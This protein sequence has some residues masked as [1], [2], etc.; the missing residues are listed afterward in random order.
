MNKLVG[1]LVK[2][3][4]DDSSDEGAAVVR[5]EGSADDDIEGG[6]EVDEGGAEGEVVD[7][8]KGDLSCVT[9]GVNVIGA[10]GEDVGVNGDAGGVSVGEIDDD[11]GKSI[12]VKVGDN[13]EGEVACGFEL[14]ID[15]GD[16]IGN[17]EVVG[18]AA[19]TSAGLFDG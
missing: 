5:G 10:D 16:E 17:R 9:D 15:C 6:D 8:G 11:E 12:S 13:V 1:S 18:V 19:D 3:E 14:I 7:E 4:F 2:E